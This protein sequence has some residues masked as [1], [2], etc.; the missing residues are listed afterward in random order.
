MAASSKIIDLRNLLA[1]R[2]Q[3]AQPHRDAG[4][5]LPEIRQHGDQ[6]LLREAAETA[7]RQFVAAMPADRCFTWIAEFNAAAMAAASDNTIT[8]AL[9]SR[10]AAK[11]L[12][13]ADPGPRP[14]AAIRNK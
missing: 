1:E 7:D 6:A 5:F 10:H 2:H 3:C 12:F 8:T 13:A 9:R 14:V 4:V 11:G